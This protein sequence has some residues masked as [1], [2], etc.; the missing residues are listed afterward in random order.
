MNKWDKRNWTLR[1]SYSR[2]Y[3]LNHYPSN[4]SK[5][6]YVYN[7]RTTT[8]CNDRTSDMSLWEIK[9]LG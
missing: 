5:C 1:P 2:T 9:I 8:T 3:A 4:E 6:L 7:V